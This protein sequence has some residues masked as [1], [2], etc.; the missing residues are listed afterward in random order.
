MDRSTRLHVIGKIS[1]YL[2]WISLICGGLVHMNL[3]KGLF[4]ALNLTQRNLLEICVVCFIICVASEVR[5]A[6]AA[7][8]EIPVMVKRAV[9]A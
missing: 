9:A 4:L 2:G 6:S 7:E 8:K 5:A 1:Y 3:A